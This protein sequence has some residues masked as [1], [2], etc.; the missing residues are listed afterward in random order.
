MPV[1]TSGKIFGSLCSLLF[2]VVFFLSY[3]AVPS[4][5]LAQTELAG[6]YGRVTDQSGAVIVDAEVEIKN[7][8]T[9][10]AVTVKTNGD[11]LYTIPSLHPGHYLISVRKPGFKAVTVTQLDLNVQDNVVRNFALQIGSVAETIT[12]TADDAH[13]NTTDGSVSTVVDRQF[14][15]NLPMNGR[16]FQTL[17]YLT[18]GVVATTSN[19]SDGGQFSVNGQR[20]SSNYWMVDGV[21]ANI[22]IGSARA[23][24]NGFAGALGSFSVLGGTNSLVSVDAM[25]EFRILTSTYAPEFG[26]TPGGQISIVTRSGT[27]Q[28]H[29]TLFDYLRND[30]LDANDWFADSKGLP[31]AKEHQNDFGGTFNGPVVKDRTF[32][33]FSYE[34]LRLLLPQTQLTTVPD[35]NARQ[36]A[37]VAMQRFLNAFPLPNGTDNPAT[38][39]GE[40]NASY[41]NPA[42]LDAY[43]LRLDHKLTKEVSLFARYNYSPSQIVQRGTAGSALNSLASNR[44]TTQTGTVGAT[45]FISPTLSNDFRFNYSRVNSSGNSHLDNFGEAVP[46]ASFPFPSPYTIQV[47]QFNLD[48]FSLSN[49]H[50][51]AG[52]IVTNRQKQVNLVDAL[53][54]QQG[55]HA[56]KF[57]FDFRRL[58]PVYDPDAYYQEADFNDVL[59]AEN[60]E[61]AG[62]AVSANRT[63]PVL[64]HNLGMFAQDTWRVAPRLTVT[65]GLRWDVDFAPTTTS[66]PSFPAAINFNDLSHFA[67]AP[68][69]TP[70]FAT[71]FGNVAPR[72]GVA[73][74]VSQ[75]NGWGTVVRGGV[76]VFFDLATAEAGDLFVLGYPFS[77]SSFPSSASFPLDASS[78]A[79]PAITLASLPS[80]VFTAFYPHL[81][82]PYTLEWSA[83]LEQG[84]GGK[85]TLAASYVGSVGRRLV[86]T[87]EAFQP[88]PGIGLAGLV[89]NAGTSDYNALQLQFQRPLSQRVQALASY[90]WSHSIDTASAG[91]SFILSNGLIPS[92]NASGNRGPSDFDIRKA[93]SAALTYDIPSP[94][95]GSFVNAIARGWS[96]ANIIQARSA[97]PVTVDALFFQFMAA[98]GDVRPDL[99]PG[100]PIYLVG[101][102]Y[103]GG[104]AFNPAAF[105]NPPTT[106]TGCNPATD[107]PCDPVRQGN[108]GRNALRGFGT[109]QWDLTVRRDFRFRDSLTLQFRAEMFNV[110]NHPNFGSPQN[111]LGIGGF[112]VSNLMLGESL[113]GG[114]LGGNLG[115]G[116]FSPLYQLGGPRSVQFSLKLQF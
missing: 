65:Y 76:G 57:G 60:G 84:L 82:L 85:Q 36:T 24:S 42:M 21:S 104:K 69:G 8:E 53:S 91:S 43:S 87:A 50:L 90:A 116:G 26:R 39:I 23:P 37:A 105:Q 1:S 109:T 70:A 4:S 99:V 98:R 25:Q 96:L 63:V 32:F 81:Q 93:F 22:G 35:M 41:S 110:L 34:G 7:V 108:L 46:L 67:P 86:Q 64:F 12:I 112:G 30:V 71:T 111:Q 73:Y 74:Q 29:G 66:G 68:S 113:N 28:F 115:G 33:F 72:V 95:H 13:I 59:S 88:N 48:I 58:S 49:G 5:A 2:G 55:L 62:A 44:I 31:K 92:T 56:L 10:Q 78:A 61:L 89:G 100:Q 6:V 3:L 106:P 101:S 17:I 77:A 54:F 15:E 79:P 9:N 103:P 80:G 51:F 38:G 97:P 52:R 102:Q 83:A 114:N 19:V 27:N 47:A 75:K 107:F 18:P 11:G 40:F 16:S 20:A 94:K 14:A 45:W